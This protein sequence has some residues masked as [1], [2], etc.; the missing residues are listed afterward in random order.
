MLPGIHTGLFWSLA[1]LEV[2]TAWASCHDIFPAGL[3]PKSA[4]DHMVNRQ[5]FG[6][7]PAVL[8]GVIIPAENLFP[9][10]FDNRAGPSDHSVEPDH[11]GERKGLRN[12][13]NHAPSVQDQCRLFSQDHIDRPVGRCDIDWLKICV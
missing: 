2:V 1:A 7:P 5:I 9:G 10:E 3:S 8:A 4:W 11:R 12:G 6:V 13:M